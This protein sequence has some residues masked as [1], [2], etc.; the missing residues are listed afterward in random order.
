METIFHCSLPLTHLTASTATRTPQRVA[1]ITLDR[2]GAG[3]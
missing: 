1:G 2:L 3:A